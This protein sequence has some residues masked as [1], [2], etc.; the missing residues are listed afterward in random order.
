MWNFYMAQVIK[1]DNSRFRIVVSMG[2]TADGR[3]IRKTT[4]FKAPEGTTPKKAEKLALEF[5]VDFE[6]KF[7]EMLN[8]PII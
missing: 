3:Q 6:R 1:Q 5:S 4:T 7:V 2:Y 8:L